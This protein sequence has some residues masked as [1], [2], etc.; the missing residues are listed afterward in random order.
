MSLAVDAGRSR[1]SP[2]RTGLRL[3]PLLVGSALVLAVTG[4]VMVYSA[5]RGS[6]ALAGIDPH[7]YVKRQALFVAVGVVAMFLVACVDYHKLEHVSTIVYVGVLFMLLVVLSPVGSHSALGAQRWFS[8]GPLQFQPSEFATLALILVMATYCSRRPDGLDFR[9]MV[10]LVLL[11]GV[12]IVLVMLQ[13]DLGTAIVLTVIL[14]VIL[15][16]TGL[17]GRYL[18]L[19]LLGAVAVVFFAVNVGLV[20]QYQID[21][22]TSFISPN[23]ASQSAIYNVTQAKNAIGAGGLFG[24]GLFHGAQTN[25]S[26]VPE[27]KSD[28]IFSAVGEQLGFV[29]AGA[30]LLVFGVLAWR[31]LRTAQM[32]RDGYGRLL[33]AGAFAMIVFSVFENVGMNMGIMPVAGIPLP[34][35]SYGGTAVI[36]FFIAVGLV[37]SVHYRST[38]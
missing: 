31:I 36:A 32:A 28:F 17:P 24:K 6:L 7:Y 12:P 10:R 1:T 4:L 27:Q 34:F 21:R 35:I 2:V 25:L 20:H 9:D 18:V 3:D 37:A 8:L 14:I 16:A 15:A 19:L 5:T 29:G 33:C 11:A 30:L 38:R 22:I 26:Y 23:A 13:P